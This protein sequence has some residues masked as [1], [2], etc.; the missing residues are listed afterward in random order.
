M[1]IFEYACDENQESPIV[2]FDR[3]ST[4]IRDAG[5]SNRVQ[6]LSWLPTALDALKLLDNQGYRIAICTNQSGLSSR[7]YTEEDLLR[8]HIKMNEDFKEIT[9]RNILAFAFCPHS[10][11]DKC[12]CRKPRNGLITWIQEYYKNTPKILFGDKQ[13]DLQ[14]ANASNIEGILVAEG[15]L[16][17][18]VRKWVEND[19][20]SS[21]T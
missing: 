17:E 15:K 9:N 13:T 5:K 19:H 10:S 16:L 14:A 18:T 6:E 11:L 20:N 3:D 2:L 21:T 7:L 1:H 12:V 4:L 8:F